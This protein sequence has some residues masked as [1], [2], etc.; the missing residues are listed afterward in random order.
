MI[1]LETDRLVLRLAQRGDLESLHQQIFS[2]PMVSKY[3][4]SGGIFT[5]H[6]SR[7]FFDDEFNFDG[8]SPYGLCIIEEKETKS[9]IGFAGLMKA[10]HLAT[11]DYEFGY[12]LAQRYWGKGYATEIAQGQI[13]WALNTLGLDQVFALV[14]E[15]NKASVNVL[16]K[17]KLS[18]EPSVTLDGQVE[19]LV[20]RATL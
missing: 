16:N 13:D 2:D 15:E 17:L 5:A 11:E 1:V 6:Q 20:F 18:Q 3:V 7:D 4:F 8:A 9:V 10:R 14:H 19:R 12:V